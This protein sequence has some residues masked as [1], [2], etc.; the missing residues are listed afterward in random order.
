MQRP[1]R[2]PGRLLPAA[3]LSLLPLVFAMGCRGAPTDAELAARKLYRLEVEGAAGSRATDS[4]DE[5]AP[6]DD[7][8][9]VPVEEAAAAGGAAPVMQS[10]ADRR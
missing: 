9:D 4:D 5:V 6:Y 10:A 8:A 2:R 1:A 7:E 3:A